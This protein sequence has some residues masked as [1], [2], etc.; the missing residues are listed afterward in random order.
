MINH[1]WACSCGAQHPCTAEDQAIGAVFHC[2]DC[3]ITWGCVRSPKGPKVWC[4]LRPSDVE[5][6]G[7]LENPEEEL[8][9]TG[10][11]CSVCGEEQYDTPSGVTCPNGHGGADSVFWDNPDLTRKE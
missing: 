9:Y 10:T 4:A 1:I 7:L 6:H 3:D 2:T 5:F 11:R 8:D